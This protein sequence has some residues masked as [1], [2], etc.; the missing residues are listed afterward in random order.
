MLSFHFFNKFNRIYHTDITVNVRACSAHK[1]SAHLRKIISAYENY[2]P[3]FVTSQGKS[4]ALSAVV[5]AMTSKPVISCPQLAL[6]A[7]IFMIFFH[8]FLFHQV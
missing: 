3:C 7:I 8:L 4:N 2:V 6:V 5:D 1:N